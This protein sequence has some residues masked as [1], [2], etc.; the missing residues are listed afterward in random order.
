MRFTF[1]VNS[2]WKAFLIG[3]E[4]GD[5]CSVHRNAPVEL[6]DHAT[7]KDPAFKAL[8]IGKY[9]LVHL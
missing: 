9:A 7:E 1:R 8:E 5:N 6:D 2:A 3:Y 4:L